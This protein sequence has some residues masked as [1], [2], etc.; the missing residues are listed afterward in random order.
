MRLPALLIL[1]FAASLCVATAAESPLPVETFFRGAE[2][3]QPRLSRDGTRVVFLVRNVPAR[4]SIAVWDARTQKG[5][6]VFVPNDYNV[7]FAFWKGDRIVFGGDAGGNE[8][9]ALRS[10]RADGTGLR[11]LSESVDRYRWSRGPVG[12]NIFS[13]L[14]DD[15]T[16]ILIAGRGTRRNASGEMQ[17]GGEYGLYRLD[18][19]SGQRLSVESWEPHATS[20]FVDDRSGH[21]FGRT[22]EAGATQILELRTMDGAYREVARFRGT[23]LPWSF[24]GLLPGEKQALL[25]VRGEQEYDRGALF[26]FDRTTLKRAQLLYEPPKGEIVGIRRRPDG[27]VIGIMREDE[28]KTMDWFDPA[29]AKLYAALKSTF[30]G[31]QIDI[32]SSTDDARMH[33]VIAHSDRNPGAYYLYDAVTPAVTLIGRVKPLIDPAKMCDREPIQYA[34]RDGLTIHGYLTRTDRTK[35][36]LIMLPHGGP[37]GPRDTWEF[38]DDAQFLA[39]RGYA[40]LQV[41]YR[42]SG[43]YG[44]KFQAAGKREWGGRMQ[45][46]L[47]DAVHWAVAQG[48]TSVDQVGIYGASYGGYAVL[49][50]L[51]FTPELYRCGANYVG[52]S[53]LRL[54]AH[55]NDLT[56]LSHDVW[57][58]EWIGDNDADLRAHSPVEFVDRIKVPSLHAYGENDPRVDINHWKVLESALK[59]HHKPYVFL[60][61]RDEGH[62]FE[63]E[64][65]RIRFYSQ[66]EQFLAEHLPTRPGQVTLGDLKTTELPAQE[67]K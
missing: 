16:H 1:T 48:I 10:I 39:N 19:G 65:S 13:I 49:A 3:S 22:M 7:D 64:Q 66:L 12:G 45:D 54:I 56:S 15:P 20:Y 27:R 51:V 60:R 2:I 44:A 61:E 14:P 36:P 24:V 18:V 35:R 62:G 46:D 28:K 37:F 23:D 32:V 63:D 8:S 31:Q 38:D 33:V 47:T 67:K 30:P 59:K 55:P 52:V 25:Q 53:D 6:I 11:D 43:G 17:W 58:A 9:F 50:G 4:N 41:N 40:V 29:W 21:V 42:G 5:A 34:A 57:V 26:A